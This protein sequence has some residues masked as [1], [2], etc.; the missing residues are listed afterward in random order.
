MKTGLCKELRLILGTMAAPLQW[1][2]L[3]F[4]FLWS[5]CAFGKILDSLKAQNATAICQRIDEQ[6]PH[7]ISYPSSSGY[8]A[9]TT[10]YFSGQEMEMRPGCIFMP[11]DASEVSR[12]VKLMSRASSED[13]QS[14]TFHSPQFA[15]RSGGHTPWSG[16]ANIDG[17]ITVDLR[18]MNSFV[19]SQARRMASIGGG[20]IWSDIY[21]QLIPYNLTVMG[22]RVVGVGVGGYLT[23][24][25]GNKQDWNQ[26][27]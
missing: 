19:L 8:N 17:G 16:A 25:K 4:Y 22:G 24:G 2:K 10:S 11:E 12:F 1:T 5:T 20:S 15:I 27:F 9:S 26:C 23:G 3:L 7:R 14:E 18:A 21:P 6:I 13:G